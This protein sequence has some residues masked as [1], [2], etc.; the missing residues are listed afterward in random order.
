MYLNVSWFNQALSLQAKDSKSTWLERNGLSIHGL[1]KWS[2]EVAYMKPGLKFRL[3]LSVSKYMFSAWNF[4]GLA[5]CAELTSQLRG[6][7][8]KRQVDGARIA[9]QHNFGIG[10]AAVVTMYKKFSKDGPV[11]L[12]SSL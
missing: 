4:T 9:L 3:F 12:K 8:G 1:W 6:E 2:W 10:G 5:Q 7:C 11:N